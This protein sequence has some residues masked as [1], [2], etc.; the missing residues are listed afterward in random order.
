MVTGNSRIAS[1]SASG[2]A[3]AAP[4]LCDDEPG[5]IVR[6]HTRSQK[7]QSGGKPEPESGR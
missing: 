5:G 7:G 6:Q 2:E 4:T 1:R 3:T